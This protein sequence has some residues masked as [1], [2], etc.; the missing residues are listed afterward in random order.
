MKKML[1]TLFFFAI[2]AVLP[3]QISALQPP[4]TMRVYGIEGFFICYRN[5]VFSQCIHD[6]LNPNK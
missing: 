5:A 1:V 6:C 2:A 4:R 3:M